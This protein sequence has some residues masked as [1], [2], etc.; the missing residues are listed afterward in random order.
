VV[1]V[2]K[3]TDPW[4]SVWGMQTLAMRVRQAMKR[5]G[6][7]HREDKEIEGVVESSGFV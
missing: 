2:G 1:Q 7:N 3:E 4:A 6:M 5:G